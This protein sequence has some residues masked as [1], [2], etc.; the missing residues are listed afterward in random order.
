M[1]DFLEGGIFALRKEIKRDCRY[2]QGEEYY[3]HQIKLYTTTDMTAEEIH[4][5]GLD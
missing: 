2:S 5:L 1:H 4:R 3:K